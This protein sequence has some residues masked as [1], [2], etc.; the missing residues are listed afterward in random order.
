M[1]MTQYNQAA[2][3]SF[4]QSWRSDLTSGFLVFLIALPLCLGISL[5]SGYPPGAG[6]LTAIIGGLVTPFF[7]NSELTIKG[8]AAGLIVIAL[9]AVQGL[10]EGDPLVGYRRAL[11]VGVVAGILQMILGRLKAGR[12]GDFFPI[13]AVHGML[14]AI[15]VIIISKQAHIALGVSP[16]AKEP[17]GL[18]AEIPDSIRNLNP[19]IALIGLL[20]LA[21]LFLRPHL[22]LAFLK[23][24]PGPLL[25]LLIAT[26]LSI[27]LDVS[28]EHLYQWA[29]HSY[30]IGPQFLVHLPGSLAQ[31]IAFPD[32]SHLLTLESFKWIMMF[33]LIGSLESVLSAKAIDLLDSENRKT[34]LNRD[35]FAVGLAN[36]VVALIGGLPMIS[37]IV[38]S[39][40]NRNNG[41][42]SRW[43][44]FFH[45]AFLLVMVATLPG[46][47]N[48][49]PLAALAA[50]L[51]F[52][53]WNLASPREFR[54]MLAIGK[55]Q[56]L[57]FSTVLVA[58]LATD[59]LLGIAVGLILKLVL[60]LYRGA[61]WRELWRVE[62][63][64]APGD[65]TEIRIAQ[66][67]VF[68]NWLILQSKLEGVG[69]VSRVRLNLSE[70]PIVDHTI[71][72]KLKETAHD[73]EAENR[74]LEID[75]LAN[76]AAVSSHPEATRLRRIAPVDQ[77]HA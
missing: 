39:T 62:W 38:R 69:R 55:D 46:L 21:I 54:H 47:L 59:L 17:L 18:L 66:P 65:V 41:A 43:A 51:V 31:V 36:T 72:R 13:A 75:G 49:I 20:S 2:R 30:R 15:G 9:G 67:L 64:V 1:Q 48:Q 53:G 71:L 3:A 42:R 16:H 77:V 60:H 11:A 57:I 29:G 6:I 23:K 58:T 50:M 4:R 61:R 37:E 63:N 74:Q 33:T 5:A 73:W 45:G 25:V 56:M 8:P 52:T 76:H 34:D 10:G 35:L 14:A 7:S 24:I 27:W 32:F 70:A 44:N 26:P 28:H 40:A 19:E 22:R 12:L 68:S